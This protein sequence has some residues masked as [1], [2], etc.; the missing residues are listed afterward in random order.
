MMCCREMWLREGIV[1]AWN[2]KVGAVSIMRHRCD[3]D[4]SAVV[5]G[6][7]NSLETMIINQRATCTRKWYRMAINAKNQFGGS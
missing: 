5:Y 7:H 4:K 2:P 6:M 1:V 3:N